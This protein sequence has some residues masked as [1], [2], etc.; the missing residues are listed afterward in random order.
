MITGLY[1]PDIG[2]GFSLSGKGGGLMK[3]AEE[4]MDGDMRLCS[5]IESNMAIGIAV[6][7][8]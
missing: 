2:R 6:L 8:R 7:A 5:I 4:V 3:F 1:I